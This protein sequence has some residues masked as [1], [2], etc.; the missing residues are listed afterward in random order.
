M[1]LNKKGSLVASV[2]DGRVVRHPD[3]SALM[4]LGEEKS[5]QFLAAY[6]S[7]CG[8]YRNGTYYGLLRNI[9]SRLGEFHEGRLT[10]FS[11]P[12][13]VYAMLVDFRT[14]WYTNKKSTMRLPSRNDVWMGFCGFLRFCIQEKILVEV[15][16]P[17]GNKK[18]NNRTVLREEKQ[19]KARDSDNPLDEN[20]IVPISLARSDDDYLDELYFQFCDSREAFLKAAL[21]EINGIETIFQEG[22]KI[23]EATDYAELTKILKTADG[24]KWPYYDRD[25]KAHLFASTHPKQKANV[26]C[27]IA[28]HHDGLFLGWKKCG[29][30]LQE[31][32]ALKRVFIHEKNVNTDTVLRA[33]DVDKYLGRMTTR[34]L[35]P[36]FV[37][38]LIKNP[39]SRIASLISVEID[40]KNGVNLFLTDAGESKG[41]VRAK[42]VKNRAHAEKSQIQD[43][44][45]LRVINLLIELTTPFRALLKKMGHPDCHKL[46]LCVDGGDSLGMPRWMNDKSLRKSFG[47][48]AKRLGDP[49]LLRNDR[50]V[51]VNSFLNSHA[52]LEPYIQSAT[53][54]KLAPIVG[55]INWFETEGNSE[56]AA[57]VLGHS[58]KTNMD[59]YIP[60]LIQSLMNERVIRRF[61]NLLICAATANM[62]RMLEASDFTSIEELHEFLAQT[63][64]EEKDQTN[65]STSEKSICRIFTDKY[66]DTAVDVDVENGNGKQLR[67]SISEHNL[68]LL[69]LYQ[70]HIDS[71]G[72]AQS[73]TEDFE[74]P[75]V[76]A[77]LFWANLS[78]AL[79]RV[80]PDSSYGR[81]FSSIYKNAITRMDSCRG[82][83]IFP[84]LG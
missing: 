68:V 70:E 69:F 80:L 27:Y 62:E 22:Q 44:E 65:A 50:S 16:I 9:L 46:W 39:K 56:S 54:S 63:L 17:Q 49:N 72:I 40:G 77:I 64:L 15:P 83:I 47:M 52:E 81:E 33:A 21:R 32:P 28:N 55:I 12:K 35:V 29:M 67:V 3:L 23:V 51:A 73:S 71:S 38:L 37:Y 53:L 2:F 59:S 20:S 36:F 6:N 11:V 19:L 25:K 4:S 7:Y 82:T 5:K 24:S 58:V 84:V 13:S 14:F 41:K 61:Q 79:H 60:R 48:N 57:K 75:E 43:L 74:Q 42:T 30:D 18:L 31:D 10:H 34:M 66:N 26:L 76:S 78:R 8:K 1:D 45:S